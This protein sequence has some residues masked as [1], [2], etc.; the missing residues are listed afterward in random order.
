[1][2]KSAADQTRCRPPD[3]IGGPPIR[4]HLREGGIGS[5]LRL[6]RI[7]APRAVAWGGQVRNVVIPLMR[8]R[9]SEQ[10]SATRTCLKA[11][12][13]ASI[14][15]ARHLSPAPHEDRAA[16][17]WTSRRA[18]GTRSRSRVTCH[19]LCG[20]VKVPRTRPSAP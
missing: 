2:K 20:L 9:G 12:S 19:L 16:S 8:A 10:A 13:A 14:V 6:H 4:G 11:A 18:G 1:M 5:S 7:S 3:L 17:R 15:A